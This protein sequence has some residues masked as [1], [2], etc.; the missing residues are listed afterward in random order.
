M[1]IKPLVKIR[2]QLRFRLGTEV[3]TKA[4]CSKDTSGNQTNISEF[5]GISQSE[6]Q[7][8]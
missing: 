4:L 7:R 6:L 3:G 8:R 1:K 5:L 2:L